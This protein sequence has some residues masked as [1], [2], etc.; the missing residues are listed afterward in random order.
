MAKV[1]LQDW[2]MGVHT[3]LLT[4]FISILVVIVVLLV[5]LFIAPL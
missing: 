1:L 2:V 4:C 3:A 5:L